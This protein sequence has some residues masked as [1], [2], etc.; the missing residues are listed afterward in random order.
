V[1]ARATDNAYILRMNDP[2]VKSEKSPD[3]GRFGR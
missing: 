1:L 2:K 3:S